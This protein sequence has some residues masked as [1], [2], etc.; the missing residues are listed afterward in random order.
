METNWRQ[1]R[2]FAV[3]RQSAELRFEPKGTE[4]IKEKMEE[5]EN[6]ERAAQFIGI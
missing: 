2:D 6:T 1:A 5:R 3:C 4:G